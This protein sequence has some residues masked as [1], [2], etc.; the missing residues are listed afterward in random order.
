[1]LRTTLLQHF[2]LLIAKCYVDTSPHKSCDPILCIYPGFRPFFFNQSYYI[3]T[4]AFFLQYKGKYTL[5]TAFNKFSSFYKDYN[6]ISKIKQLFNKTLKD[7][8]LY[9]ITGLYKQSQDILYQRS[10]LLLISEKCTF[11][12]GL[13]HATCLE[14]LF[15]T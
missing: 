8:N 11:I 14:L 10:D 4:I 12:R 15:P 7:N 1:M 2:Y 6:N 13:V 9:I 3:Y 5:L